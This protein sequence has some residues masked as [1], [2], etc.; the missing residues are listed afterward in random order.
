MVSLL[1]GVSWNNLVEKPA[2]A[3]ESCGG[4]LVMPGQPSTSYLYQKLT[5]AMPCSGAQMPLGEFASLPLPDCAVA[6]VR[7]WIEEGAPPPGGDAG[8]D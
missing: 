1:D 6:I 2:P 4:V 5:N 3:P 8:I 7:A